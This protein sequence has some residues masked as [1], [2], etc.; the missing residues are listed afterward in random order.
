LRKA[1]LPLIARMGADKKIPIILFVVVILI[2]I[3]CRLSH[4]ARLQAEG[5][6]NTPDGE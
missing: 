2:G 5:P 1:F 3:D 4:K 6:T